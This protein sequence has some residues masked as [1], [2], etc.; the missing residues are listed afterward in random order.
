MP[1]PEISYGIPAPTESGARLALVVMGVSGTGKTTIGLRLAAAMGCRF[2]EGDDLHSAENVAKMRAGIP[3]TDDD[4]WPW[5]ERIAGVINDGAQ[6]GCVVSCSALRRTYRDYL[7][8]MSRAPLLFVHPLVNPAMIAHRMAARE[9]HYMP[10]GLLDSQL[11][12]FEPPDDDEP[13]I[14]VPGSDNPDAV[15]HNILSEVR[16]RTV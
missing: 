10:P 3:L 9:N 7:V 16:L 2:H 6:S 4:R 15:V 14:S 5:L 8:R 1:S 12:T 13:V 11:L